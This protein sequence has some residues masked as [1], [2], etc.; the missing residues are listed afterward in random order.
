MRLRVVRTVCLCSLV[1]LLTLDSPIAHRWYDIDGFPL[2]P[3]G[4]KVQAR[5]ERC[6]LSLPSECVAL[7]YSVLEINSS[8]RSR[9]DGGN[10]EIGLIDFQG[11]WEGWETVLSFPRFPPTGISIVCFGCHIPHA[12]SSEGWFSQ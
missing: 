6:L 1:P 12:A 8:R 3:A 2:E 7:R 4:R 10:V 9:R 5:T 11:W